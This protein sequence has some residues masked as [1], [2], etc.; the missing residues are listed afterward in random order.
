MKIGRMNSPRAASG[1]VAR[2]ARIRPT[3]SIAGALASSGGG[4]IDCSGHPQ[5][6]IEHG[7][8]WDI[9]PV[10]RSDIGTPRS[11][12]V[13]S[14]LF[15]GLERRRISPPP[16]RRGLM[17]KGLLGP[18]SALEADVLAPQPAA[19]VAVGWWPLLAS[20]D[21]PEDPSWAAHKAS[22]DRTPGRASRKH[23]VLVVDD[24]SDVRTMLRTQLEID[25]YEV[26]EAADG[27]Q[28]WRMIQRDH[29][30]VVVTD[31]QM[32][33]G[34]GL[35]LCSLARDKGFDDTKFIAF[36]AGMASWEECKAAGF[37]AHFLKTDPLPSL[38][39]TIR[40]YLSGG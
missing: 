18:A 37:D 39:R 36:T 3:V 20:G 2:K 19:P 29:P 22:A 30:A 23:R 10:K 28:A 34:N 26:F 5:R 12:A 8:T 14:D 38:S 7:R 6:D 33:Q 1:L 17:G 16:N 21:L 13:T 31:I 4:R 40:Q 35:E 15:T 27:E 11:H 9:S 25:G 32:P 24:D